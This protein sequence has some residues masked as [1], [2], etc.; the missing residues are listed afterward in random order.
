M[1]TRR[2]RSS[3]QVRRRRLV[4]PVDQHG[5]AVDGQARAAVVHGT[6]IVRAARQV[7]RH[8]P[9]HGEIIRADA[10][11][12]CARPVERQVRPVDARQGRRAA[13]RR[14]VEIIAPPFRRRRRGGGL[15]PPMTRWLRCA[16]R[17]GR[18]PGRHTGRCGRG[19]ERHGHRPRARALNA[20]VR[21]DRARCVAAG[22]AGRRVRCRD[23]PHQRS[24]TRAR[25]GAT[26]ARSRARP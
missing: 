5:P 22:S 10:R 3:R 21:S 20:A 17:P 8:R 12:R 26:A 11:R 25:R 9:A 13:Q 14:V 6:K 19:R 18:S 24:A 2:D 7:Q 15:C 1:H 4:P 23:A 16:P